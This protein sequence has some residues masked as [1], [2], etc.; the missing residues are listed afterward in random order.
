MD[1][2]PTG[3][4]AYGGVAW[5]DGA[6][7]PADQARISVFDFGFTRSDVTYD[8]VHVWN[9]AF[10]RLDHHL[11]RFL[12]SVATLRMT[13]PVDR[14][15][16]HDILAGCVARSGLRDAYVAMVCTRGRPPPGSRDLRQCRNQLIAYALPFIW[17]SDPAAQGRGMSA[18]LGA[19]P[20]IPPESVDPRVKNY[21]WLDLDRSLL[22]AY[23]RGADTA[24]LLDADGNV[25]EGPGF[26]VFAVIGDTVVTPDRGV[27]EGIS[28]QTVIDI[29]REQ[30]MKLEVRSLG[31]AEFLDAD[32]IFATSTAGGVMPVVRIEN[33]ILGNGA[34]GPV[35]QKLRTLYWGRHDD[36]RE[37][38]EVDYGEAP[39]DAADAYARQRE[40]I[41]GGGR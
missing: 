41:P 11:D 35:S 20:R 30:G 36:P 38:T 5:M 10:F 7:V 40:L 16:L 18:I 25:T 15:G 34:P 6:Y 26:N 23:D 3:L 8:V 31:R 37:R 9:G 33:R 27:L 28:R 12:A 1:G 13:L 24:I 29:C 2:M 39:A 17:L 32:E 14:A 19:F 21:H 22:E 4:P